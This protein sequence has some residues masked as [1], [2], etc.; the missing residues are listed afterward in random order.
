MNKKEKV[1]YL[2]VVLCQ[3]FHWPEWTKFDMI[4]SILGAL[5]H[6]HKK[7]C[8]VSP[9]IQAR[10]LPGEYARAWPSYATHGLKILRGRHCFRGL[11]C[12]LRRPVEKKNELKFQLSMNHVLCRFPKPSPISPDS[13]QPPITS[14]PS[15]QF[16]GTTNVPNLGPIVREIGPSWHHLNERQ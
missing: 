14:Y 12:Q 13:L 2:F 15:L 1:T 9:V 4:L 11:K 6:W 5:E 7:R 3:E 8:I 16:D 10:S